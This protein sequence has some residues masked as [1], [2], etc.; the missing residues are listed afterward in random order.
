MNGKE[1]AEKASV[2][3]KSSLQSAGF[4]SNDAKSVWTPYCV[5]W[6]GF[7]I[8]LLKGCV[9][10]LQAKQTISMGIAL[11]LVARFMTRHLNVLLEFK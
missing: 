2:W 4:V 8:D 5:N 1:S 7:D 6:L 11:G 10:V 9:S 3:V